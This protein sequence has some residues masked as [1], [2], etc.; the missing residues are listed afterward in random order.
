MSRD[1]RRRAWGYLCCLT[2]LTTA[3]VILQGS[4]SRAALPVQ[5]NFTLEGCNRPTGLTLPRP[6]GEFICPDADYTTGNQGGNWADLDLVPF[7]LIARIT[8]A[9]TFTVVIAAD[10]REGAA[11]GFDDI[12]VP[13]VNPGLSGPNCRAPQVGALETVNPGLGGTDST[14]IR[15]LVIPSGGDETCVYDWHQRL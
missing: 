13:T 9:Q 15:R 3:L 14:I 5:V 10:S 7:R 12:S 11:T 8:P 4:D 6:D 1:V 2:L